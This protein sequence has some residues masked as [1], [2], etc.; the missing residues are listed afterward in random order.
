MSKAL[1]LAAASAALSTAGLGCGST[2]QHS[3]MVNSSSNAP[4]SPLVDRDKC[5]DRDKHVITSDTN[6]D[7]KPDVWTYY[8]DDKI[9]RV[10]RDTDY[11]GKVDEWQYYEG[12]KLDR[13]GYDTTGTGRL[14]RWDRA[15]EGEPG[16]GAPGEPPTGGGAA[17]AT[18]PPAAGATQ[19]PAATAPPAAS[20]PATQTAKK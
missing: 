8:E 20:P 16:G 17:P 4:P 6:L 2:P 1:L 13:I 10:E 14:D 19:P 18:T 7:K 5:N 12:G 11:N 3:E 15:P 9:V